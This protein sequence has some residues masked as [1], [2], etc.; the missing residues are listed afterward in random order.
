MPVYKVY[1][2]TSVFGGCFDLGFELPSRAIFQQIE[3]GEL[4][5]LISDVLVEELDGAPDEVKALLQQLNAKCVIR[6]PVEERAHALAL[7]YIENG[8]LPPKSYSDALHV[9]VATLNGADF[10]VSWNFKHLVNVAQIACFN[11]V[12]HS[13]SLRQIDIRT[14]T[15][16][17]HDE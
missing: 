3:N 15:E 6:V 11:A 1:V 5:A 13:S 14:P 4:I 9:A 16:F 12:N 8:V 10:I 2:D 7:R 17:V